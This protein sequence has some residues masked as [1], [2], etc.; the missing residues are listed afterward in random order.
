[1]DLA[2][3]ASLGVITWY[4][5]I[6]IHSPIELLV[7]AIKGRILYETDLPIEENVLYFSFDYKLF[8]AYY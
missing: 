7:K 4:L 5:T 2:A 6:F 3:A 1:M 8:L